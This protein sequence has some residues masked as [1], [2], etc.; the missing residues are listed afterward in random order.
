MSK[1]IIEPCREVDHEELTKWMWKQ[2]NAIDLLKQ[3]V[4]V[5][6]DGN[7]SIGADDQN[8]ITDYLGENAKGVYAKL[9]CS[10]GYGT[11]F[12]FSHEED[13]ALF[14]LRFNDT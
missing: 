3:H 4:I 5:F 12:L 2:D 6:S 7:R 14:T 11:R 10:T 8:K 13:V 1:L 9:S